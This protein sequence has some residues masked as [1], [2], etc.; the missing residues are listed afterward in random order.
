MK[1]FAQHGFNLIELMT[2]LALTM[3]VLAAI[4]QMFFNTRMISKTEEEY[5]AIQDN[6]RFAIN[7]LSQETR[8]AGYVGCTRLGGTPSNYTSAINNFVPYYHNFDIAIE[9][10]HT[11]QVL[12]AELPTN[13]ILP[14]TDILIIRR[15][16]SEGFRML[17]Q[18]ADSSLNIEFVSERQNACPGG[19]DDKINGLCPGDIVI[20]SDCEKAKSFVITSI[21]TIF[22]ASGD[23]EVVVNHAGAKNSPTTWGGPSSEIALDKFDPQSAQ[24]TGATTTAYFIDDAFALRRQVNNEDTQIVIQGVEN[25]H[26]L[27]GVDTDGDG[28]VNRYVASNSNLL[29]ADPQSNQPLHFRN[30]ISIRL[31]LIMRSNNAVT[32]AKE[33]QG[34]SQTTIDLPFLDRTLTLDITDGFIR[35][36]I[37]TTVYLRNTR[38][39]EQ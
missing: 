11:S 29:S 22:N 21:T 20:L 5:T 8:M 18:K 24:L 33:E 19:A 9:G 34:N 3:I 10:Y 25:M 12:P 15:V 14:D 17:R 35:H 31:A 1:R 37:D 27:Y 16:N 39:N 32:T 4:N 30:V 7:K 28:S 36:S 13:K 6:A 38:R 23:R 26:I 2:A